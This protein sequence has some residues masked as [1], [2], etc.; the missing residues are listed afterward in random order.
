MCRWLLVA[1]SSLA[2]TVVGPAMMA[3]GSDPALMVAA[4]VTG[5]VLME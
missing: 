5:S 1:G 3:P 2:M 4:G